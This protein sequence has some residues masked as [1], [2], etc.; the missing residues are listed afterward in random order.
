MDAIEGKHFSIAD[1]KGIKTVIYQINKTRK[2]FLKQY[3]KYTV[4]RLDHTE[5]IAGDYN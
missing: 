5:E 3:P 2:E 4:E 1:P